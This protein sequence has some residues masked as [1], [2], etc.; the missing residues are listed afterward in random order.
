MHKNVYIPTLFRQAG[1]RIVENDSWVIYSDFEN[2]LTFSLSLSI[3]EKFP[4]PSGRASQ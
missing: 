3:R 4:I 2:I 1:L